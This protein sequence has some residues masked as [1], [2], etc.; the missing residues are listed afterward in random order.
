MVRGSGWSG[1][2]QWFVRPWIWDLI[3][4]DRDLLGSPEALEAWSVAHRGEGRREIARA[5]NLSD[6]SPGVVL[7]EGETAVRGSV[8]SGSGPRRRR[9]HPGVAWLTDQS[10]RGPGAVAHL[11]GLAHG[12]H[13]H[14]I[15]LDDHHHACGATDK[16]GGRTALLATSQNSPFTKRG[17]GTQLNSWTRRRSP[18]LTPRK[19]GAVASGEGTTRRV[20]NEG[21]ATTSDGITRRRHAH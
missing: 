13:P 19:A 15:I 1:S 12:V 8:R 16:P 17:E 9:G 4:G 6:G 10:T 21:T 14:A 3:S 11:Q 2:G 20:E 5:H 18:S 7:R